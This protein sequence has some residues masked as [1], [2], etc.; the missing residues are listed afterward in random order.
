M[1]EIDKHLV[2]VNTA[3]DQMAYKEPWWEKL[4]NPSIPLFNKVGVLL[5]R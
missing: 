5:K 2:L 1:I 3:V 4:E